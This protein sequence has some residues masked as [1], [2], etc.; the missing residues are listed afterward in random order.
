MSGGAGGA[1]PLLALDAKIQGVA[2]VASWTT[3]L[4]NSPTAGFS[5][6]TVDL[7]TPSHLTPDS[8]TARQ[9]LPKDLPR[10]YR[11]A[12]RERGPVLEIAVW[13]APLGSW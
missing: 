11:V 4:S 1:G 12:L 10:L 3:P 5:F 2:W 8:N 9:Q 7:L 13:G 6:D